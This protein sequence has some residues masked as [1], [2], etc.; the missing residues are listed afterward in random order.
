MTIKYGCYP[1]D[2]NPSYFYPCSIISLG[3]LKQYWSNKTLLSQLIK[4]SPYKIDVYGK[5]KPH[6]KYDINYKGYAKSLDIIY[7]YQFGVNTVSKDN[8][9][10]NHFSSRIISYLA[11]GLPVLFPEWQKFPNKLKGCLS[12]N[13]TNFVEVIE[14]YSEKDKW[15]KICIEAKEQGKELDWKITLR[16]LEKLINK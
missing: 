9:R 13:E 1:K 15:E 5:H 6:E 12:Y 11:H 16:P 7:D 14:E 10:K 8:F 3:N 4:T 2:K